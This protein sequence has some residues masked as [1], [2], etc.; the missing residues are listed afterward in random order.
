MATSE[1]LTNSQ[2]AFTET[3]SM[4]IEQVASPDSSF[5]DDINHLADRTS[6]LASRIIEQ[7]DACPIGAAEAETDFNCR[8][9]HFEWADQ[10]KHFL[11]LYRNIQ[12]QLQTASLLVHDGQAK[13][14]LVNDLHQRSTK[15]LREALQEWEETDGQRRKVL[16]ANP[17]RR[18]QE[19]ERWALLHNPWPEYRQQFETIKKQAGDLAQEHE[20]LQAQTTH[21]KELRQLLLESISTADKAM[22]QA[23]E[24]ATEIIQFLE[25]TE[26]EESK[27]RPGQIATRLDEG[28]SE[29]DAVPRLSEMTNQ[30][31]TLI[32]KLAETSRVTVGADYGVMSYKDV[33]F[34]KATEQW[35]S[36]EVMPQLYELWELSEQ[37]TNG[38]NVATANARNRALLMASESAEAVPY[39][40]SQLRQPFDAFL[41][42]SGNTHK[43]FD[44]IAAMTKELVEKDLHL[45][46]V[47]RPT[48]GF[49]PL[50]LQSGI[51]EFTRRQGRVLTN[52]REW[53]GSTFAGFDRL[54]GEAAR[55]DRMSVSEKTVRVIR[56]RSA[57]TNNSAYTNILMTKGYIGES[58]LVG[59]DEETAHLQQL[60]NNW[61]NG[62]RGAVM[63]TGQ[64]LSGRTLF[65]ELITN[66]FFPNNGIRLRPNSTINIKGRRFQTT[67]N[68]CDALDF[69]VKYGLQSSPLVWIDDLET[70]WDKENSLAENIRKL[71]AHIDNNSGKIFYLVS[72]TNA[73]YDHLNRFRELDRIFQSEV[74][75][76]EFSLSDMQR[77]VLI[78]HGATHKM[79]V[80]AE[81]EPLSET[82]FAKLIKKLHRSSNGVVGDT[83]NKWAY[84]TER[85]DE[86]KVTPCQDKQY[87]LPDFLTAD[88]GILLSTIFLEKRTN[89]YRLRKLMGPAFQSHY[90]SVL[91]RLQR[92]GLVTRHNDG[93]LEIPESVVNEVARL[94]KR[95]EYLKT[96][97]R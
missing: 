95:N 51:N 62:F 30:L 66:R 52:V 34:R 13:P 90:R 37:V 83:L 40:L 85:V 47:Y 74:N 79:M 24:R 58:F 97:I 69:I 3:V 23:D 35:I 12:L 60:I 46:A 54:R 88:T 73:V 78:R 50:P 64:R 25:A 94:L 38:L 19:L 33:N 28:L 67:G 53:F 86:E 20:L 96:T 55:E 77:A 45:S 87:Y 42:R 59:R 57:P 17:K 89:E 39:D 81:G 26:G 91:Q 8:I 72:T 61:R 31:S 6:Q 43:S 84:L 22:Y 11:L 4:A 92:V 44:E 9:T 36:A 71:S 21:F 76:D 70:W 49:L 56:Q 16:M 5:R 75:L 15:V 68:L 10:A 32:S 48:P 1:L 27:A 80:D 14:G 18:A 65:G 41:K 63:L 93:W 29:S 82:A 7:G 2:E